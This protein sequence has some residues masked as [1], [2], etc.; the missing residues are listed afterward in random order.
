M[1]ATT[2][3]VHNL[4]KGR[5]S[6]EKLGSGFRKRHHHRGGALPNEDDAFK[7]NKLHSPTPA[8]MAGETLKST[9]DRLREMA[10]EPE[11]TNN[12]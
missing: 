11:S 6:T 8:T 1:S 2:S 12:C 9:K 10:S 3:S 7:V 4:R 5:K